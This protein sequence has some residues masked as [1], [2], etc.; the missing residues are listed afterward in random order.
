VG[1]VG[2]CGKL[3]VFWFFRGFLGV[4]PSVLMWFWVFWL[5]VVDGFLGTSVIVGFGVLR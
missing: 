1:L 5:A 4:F 3:R 2:N